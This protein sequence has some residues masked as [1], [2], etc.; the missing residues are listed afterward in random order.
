MKFNQSSSI[1]G[2][3]YW[4][5]VGAQIPQHVHRLGRCH[6]LITHTPADSQM[7]LVCV[8]AF[9]TGSCIHEHGLLTTFNTTVLVSSCQNAEVNGTVKLRNTVPMSGSHCCCILGRTVRAYSRN[10]KPYKLSRISNCNSN[11]ELNPILKVCNF[12][13]HRS[14]TALTVNNN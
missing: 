11:S 8:R 4:G 6:C 9:I 1:N 13:H 7:K 12:C 10:V 3:P 5:Y 2:M 14:M